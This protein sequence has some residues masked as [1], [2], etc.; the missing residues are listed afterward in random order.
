[1]TDRFIPPSVGSLR[2]FVDAGVLGLAEVHVVATLVESVL[3]SVPAGRRGD[4][5]VDGSITD[6]VVLAAALAV[7]APLHGHVRV[8]LTVGAAPVVP[9]ETRTGSPAG[10][11]AGSF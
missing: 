2:P 7:R 5:V 11:P 6:D 3:R 9:I 8:D 10:S 4:D 1:M